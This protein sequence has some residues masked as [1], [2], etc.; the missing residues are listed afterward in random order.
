[1]IDPVPY[2]GPGFLFACL[3]DA[4]QEE[5]SERT[6]KKCRKIDKNGGKFAIRPNS[7]KPKKAYIGMHPTKIGPYTRSHEVG[8]RAL[9][10][11]GFAGSKTQYMVVH[12]V[13]STKFCGYEA[14]SGQL[15]E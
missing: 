12:F 4:K 5:K 1:L 10:Y 15:Q 9:E 13:F 8:S 7:G 14:N 3:K 11:Q 2:G 6:G